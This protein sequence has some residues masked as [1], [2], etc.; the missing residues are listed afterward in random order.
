MDIG[1]TGLGM[2]YNQFTQNQQMNNQQTLMDWQQ[3]NQMELNQQG[4]NLQ[5]DMWLATNYGPQKDQMLKAGLNP[6]LMYGMKGG[7]GTTTGSQSGGSAQG[8]QAPMAKMM[9]INQAQKLKAET[10]LINA[11]TTK[12]NAETPKV[13]EETG[14]IEAD[15]VLKFQNV[16]NAQAQESLTNLE[17]EYQ[18]IQNNIASKTVTEAIELIKANTNNAL[19]RLEI[20]K[21][22]KLISDETYENEIEIVNLQRISLVL[23]NNLT[24]ADIAL[25]GEQL[26]QVSQS[27]DNMIR[28]NMFREDNLQFIHKKLNEEMQL[29]RDQ[30]DLETTKAIVQGVNQTAGTVMSI[31]NPMKKTT[32]IYN[33][34]KNPVK[35]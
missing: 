14:N 23:G 6:A 20:L 34:I 31:L 30:L 16:K 3:E 17:I 27:I 26:K 8:G 19:E 25:K 24:N 15:T 18:N 5:Y 11:Q 10:D 28:D 13:K 2:L 12:L 9:D 7:G 29:K 32:N 21:N 4:K 22:D 1:N 35:K 33:T